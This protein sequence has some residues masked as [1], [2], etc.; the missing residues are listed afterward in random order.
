M[1][2]RGKSWVAAAKAQRRV[3]AFSRPAASSVNHGQFNK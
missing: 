1:S 2:Y 3:F